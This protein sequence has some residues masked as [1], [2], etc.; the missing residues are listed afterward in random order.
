MAAPVLTRK[1]TPFDGISPDA[2]KDFAAFVRTHAPRWIDGSRSLSRLTVRRARAKA[3]A[4]D[5]RRGIRHVDAV[6]RTTRMSSR[7]R[8]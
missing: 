7:R 2:I 3:V 6:D 4:C 1:R 5:R 8:R